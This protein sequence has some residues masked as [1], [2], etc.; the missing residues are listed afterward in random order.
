[1]TVK[2]KFSGT[3]GGTITITAG[4]HT[5]CKN[6]KLISG[7]AK[8]S[9]ASNTSLPAGTYHVVAAYSGSADFASSKSGAVTLKVTKS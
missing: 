5:V 3:P 1:M 9:P 6:A 4:T 8:C 7:K 2:P